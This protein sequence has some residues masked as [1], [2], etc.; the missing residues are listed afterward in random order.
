[1]DSG[2]FDLDDPAPKN[3]EPASNQLSPIQ[4]QAIRELFAQLGVTEAR[5][6]FDMVAELT[7]VRIASVVELDTGTANVLLQMLQGR[8]AR[9][10]RANTGNAWADRDEDT[11]IDR[12]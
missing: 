2:L 11:W 8:V 1:M 5:A 9:S 7:G 3:E 4:R 6:Q 10:G 12:L